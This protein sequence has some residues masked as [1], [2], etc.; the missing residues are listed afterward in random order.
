MTVKELLIRRI[1]ELPED[2]TQE[3]ILRELLF[4]GMVDRGL[5]QSQRGEGITSEELKRRI[6]SWRK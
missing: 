6:D 1:R 4:Y 2:S 3:E 5:A